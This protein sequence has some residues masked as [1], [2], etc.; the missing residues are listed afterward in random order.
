MKTGF[1][2]KNGDAFCLKHIIGMCEIC[3]KYPAFNAAE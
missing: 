1:I 3:N 2:T